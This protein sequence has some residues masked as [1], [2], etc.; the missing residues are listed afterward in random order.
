M[1]RRNA[2]R[3]AQDGPR[4][5]FVRFLEGNGRG[6][7]RPTILNVLKL[8]SYSEANFR[9]EGFLTSN[10]WCCNS[11]QGA[12]HRPEIEKAL[13]TQVNNVKTPNFEHLVL[14]FTSPKSERKAFAIAAKNRAR[15]RI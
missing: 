5:R 1:T 3:R 7:C 14:Q 8:K 6:K 4:N 13:L 10:I 9:V 11:R 15:H 12:E 2:P